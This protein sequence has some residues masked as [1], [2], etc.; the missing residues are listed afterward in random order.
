M[1][2]HPI[3]LSNALSVPV[4]VNP[5]DRGT[6]KPSLSYIRKRV[7]Q[8]LHSGLVLP[9]LSLTLPPEQYVLA[10]V[11]VAHLCLLENALEDIDNPGLKN[12]L[13]NG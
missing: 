10:F 8:P 3:M 13:H 4:I 9:F 11:L 7:K 12:C 5:I 6:I 1:Y 2:H